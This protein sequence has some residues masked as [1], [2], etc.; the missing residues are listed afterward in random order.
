[1]TLQEAHAIQRRELISLRATVARLEKQSSGLFPNEEKEALERRVRH[2]EQTVK[3]MEKRYASALAQQKLADS[4]SYDLE[5]ELIE[6]KELLSSLQEENAVLRHRAETAENEVRMLNGTNKKLEKK[7]NTSFENSSLPS[8]ALPFRKKV[9]NS[10]KPTGRKP[11]AQPGHRPHNASRLLSTA[12]PVYL[13]V[14]KEFLNNP[15]IYPTGKVI[16]K[17]LVDI[18]VNVYVRDFIA[19]EYRSRTTGA[20]MHA[21][22]PSGM[23]N[24]VTYGASVKAFAFLLNNYYNVSIAKTR[25]CISDIT[26]GVINLSTGTISNLSG[27]FSAATEADRAKIFSLLTHADVL[28]SDATVSNINGSRKAVILCTDKEQV[29]YQHLDHKG[30]DGL[31][32]T[33]VKNFDGTLVH[34]HDRSYYS[35]GSSHQECIAHV[36]RYLVGAMENEPH[37][38]WHRQMHSLLQK[39]IHTVKRHKS[40]VP[41]DKIQ[42]LTKKYEFTLSIG[43]R[44][45]QDTPPQKEYMDGYNLWKRLNEF[46]KDHLYFLSH[47]GVDY[48]N[49]ISERGLRKFKRKQKQAVVLRS[50]SGGQH[51]CDALTIIE[52]ARMQHKNIYDTVEAAFTH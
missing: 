25:Q 37:L 23:V 9:P 33:P 43:A 28:Y 39:M 40:G 2:L 48:T 1:M 49:N 10:R 44:E 51:I 35:Y 26:R 38:T 29:L 52:T 16:T 19:E 47:P 46:Q 5:L 32:Q 36:L 11:G 12:E 50:S 22:F 45:Y 31:L 24:D 7:L 18:R 27:E 4:R 13:P 41:K 20:R 30:H 14:P 15:D 6:L 34:D 17:Q 8:S 3:T 21:P 42:A